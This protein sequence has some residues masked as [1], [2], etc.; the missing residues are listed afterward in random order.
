[1]FGVENDIYIYQEFLGCVKY[2]SKRSPIVLNDFEINSGWLM[3][4]VVERSLGILQRMYEIVLIYRGRVVVHR[5]CKGYMVLLSVKC[6]ATIF[7]ALNVIRL[8]YLLKH[9]L[10]FRLAPKKEGRIL[11]V[12][13][14][15]KL[16]M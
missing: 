15:R 11:I 12:L 5:F 14:A 1:M 13:L 4:I 10:F 9:D 3:Y 7:K 6:L 16:C 2:L 8:L